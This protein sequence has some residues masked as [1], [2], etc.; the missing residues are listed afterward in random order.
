M[1]TNRC[2]I[3]GARSHGKTCDAVCT[4]AR[5]AGVTREEQLRLDM[6][7]WQ[8]TTRDL[9]IKMFGYRTSR[10]ISAGPSFP[11]ADLSVGNPR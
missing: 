2:I 5:K 7:D 11:D 9:Q 10:E 1:K 8:W 3:C 6:D 4:K